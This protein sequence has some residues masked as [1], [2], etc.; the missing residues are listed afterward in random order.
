MEAI[1]VTLGEKVALSGNL[2]PRQLR[3]GARSEVVQHHCLPQ[4]IGHGQ[5]R[6]ERFVPHLRLARHVTY[7]AS[8]PTDN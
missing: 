3:L 4:L 6:C 7:L 5:L 2:M 8:W 1:C